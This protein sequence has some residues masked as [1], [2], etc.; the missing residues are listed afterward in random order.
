MSGDLHTDKARGF[1]RK[2]GPGREQWERG[3]EK[4]NYTTV[5]LQSC[6]GVMVMR[7]ISGLSLVN[8]LGPYLV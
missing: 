3:G 7:L 1:I 5:A 8:H 4:Q 2:G 6:A